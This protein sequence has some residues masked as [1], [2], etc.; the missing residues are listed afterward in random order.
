M[1]WKKKTYLYGALLGLAAGLLTAR[2]MINDAEKNNSEVT[3]DLEK[4]AKIGM[5]VLNT[6][7]K[8]G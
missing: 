1:D 5:E 2:M 8:L 7:R 4:G 6:V 3:M